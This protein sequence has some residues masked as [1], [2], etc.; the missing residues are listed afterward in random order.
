[1][2]DS[3]RSYICQVAYKL[4]QSFLF[5][6]WESGAV[7]GTM[8][9]VWV[10]SREGKHPILPQTRKMLDNRQPRSSTHTVTSQPQTTHRNTW[11]RNSHHR[12][13]F[14][15]GSTQTLPA[16]FQCDLFP[17]PHELVPCL[18]LLDLN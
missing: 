12:G 15:D 11:S 3:P 8:G 17:L 4:I 1:M 18:H 6:C 5:L 16:S 9:K 10:H 2:F 13:T 7:E 14:M